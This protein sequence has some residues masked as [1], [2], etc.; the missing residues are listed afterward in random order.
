MSAARKLLTNRRRPA[1]PSRPYSRDPSTPS[2]SPPLPGL[3]APPGLLRPLGHVHPRGS[4]PLAGASP[5]ER[6][7][8]PPLFFPLPF[9]SPVSSRVAVSSAG[10]PDSLLFARRRPRSTAV[11]SAPFVYRVVFL[12]FES[13]SHY[14]VALV[15]FDLVA[16]L[17]IFLPLTPPPKSRESRQALRPLACVPVR[18]SLLFYTLGHTGF[19]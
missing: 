12:T 7:L 11:Q 8:L 9:S 15:S 10:L 4:G 16:N 14:V 18:A 2:R 3:G 19:A 6:A 17:V 5:G 13:A 1:R